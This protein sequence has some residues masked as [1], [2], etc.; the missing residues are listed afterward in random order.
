MTLPYTKRK[1]QSNP[2]CCAVRT[3]RG[4]P[5][6]DC[7]CI[8]NVALQQHIRCGRS[9]AAPASL[10]SPTAPQRAWPLQSAWPN[11][12]DQGPGDHPRLCSVDTTSFFVW[13]DSDVTGLTF[14]V[15][16]VLSSKQ[17]K[18]ATFSLWISLS[19]LVLIKHLFFPF[20]SLMLNLVLFQYLMDLHS[21]T[22]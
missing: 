17:H 14:R 22:Y 18:G 12:L 3:V 8:D 7:S 16:D 11:P 6:L 13:R 5:Q 21:L 2:Q 1:S 19:P 20:F 15:K 4:S 9:T 10:S